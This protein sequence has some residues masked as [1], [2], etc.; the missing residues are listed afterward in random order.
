MALPA[1]SYSNPGGAGDRTADITVT[2]STGLITQSPSNLVD[3]LF[4]SNN[5]DSVSFTAGSAAGA[6]IRFDFGPEAERVITEVTWKQSG[7]HSHGVFQWR[8]SNDLV[9][10]TDIGGTFTLGGATTQIQTTL[11]GNDEGYR[12]YELVGVSGT[13]S[14][15]PYIQEV[16]FKIG[17]TLLDG[18]GFV[19][20]GGAAGDVLVKTSDRDGDTA[21][22][23]AR[24]VQTMPSGIVAEWY[25]DEGAGDRVRNVRGGDGASDIVFDATYRSTY[26]SSPE[27]T[28]RG[29]K[30]EQSIV[31]TAAAVSGVRTVATLYR[32][33]RGDTGQ[34]I[35]AGN[36]AG[37]GSGQGIFGMTV[38]PMFTNHV[39]NGSGIAPVAH[40]SNGQGA[41]RLNRG[42]WLLV[43]VEFPA[44][45]NT[46]I[47]WG[48]RASAMTNRCQEL[49]I[50]WAGAWSGQLS[51][52][53][54]E[55]AFLSV[56]RLAT[57]REIYLHWAD[58]PDYIDCVRFL[59]QSGVTGY[60]LISEFT[61]VALQN[62]TQPAHS[63]LVSHMNSSGGEWLMHEP[64]QFKYNQR[65]TRTTEIFSKTGPL[66]G[67]AWAHEDNIT[68]RRRPM[69]V[70]QSAQDSTTITINPTYYGEDMTWNAATAK[71]GGMLWAS[72]RHWWETEQRLLTQGIGPRL[73]VMW[74]FQG[75]E[76][77]QSFSDN[78]N[79]QSDIQGLWDAEKLYIGAGPE[80]NMKLIKTGPLGRPP[81]GTANGMVEAK[82]DEVR[83]AQEAFAAA[84]PTDVELIDCDDLPLDVNEHWN[85]QGSLVMGQRLYAASTSISQ[86]S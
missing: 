45:Y 52:D 46:V 86:G 73:R 71:A 85:G 42:G 32:I 1:P 5:S 31:Q 53:D 25:F 3:G 69:L 84:N 24:R 39:A 77:G 44:A 8:A 2:T 76:D 22:S 48:G 16:E 78:T 15:S 65:H 34:V 7:A 21:F 10:Y 68:V 51:D 36:P 20:D 12:Y 66:P 35:S 61:D 43:F 74:Y 63:V 60:S 54:R 37:G 23:P 81:Y 4:G 55:A 29:L 17:P 27:W 30:L 50:A 47:G 41:F 18:R 62:R 49:E 9:S 14:V 70:N 79:W 11:S 57:E 33:K 72:M 40:D 75:E 58:C 26:N 13:R 82:I 28:R 38:Q 64:F 56:R 80:Y 67:A 19:P 59:G 6:Y 83:A